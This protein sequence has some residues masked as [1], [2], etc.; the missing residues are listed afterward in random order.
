MP[1]N[2]NP[3]TVPDER[4][5]KVLAEILL[6]EEAGEPLDLSRAVRTH[7][8]LEGP[9]REYFRDRDGFDR[10][11]SNPAPTASRPAVPPP[12][13]LASGSQFAG[14]EIVRELGRGGMGVV[15]LAQQRS[16]KRPVALKLIRMDRL[17]HLSARQ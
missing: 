4:F 13:D 17:A 12:P 3:S 16:A 10:L 7:P 14:Y 11:A 15:Y 5:E 1:D 9:L 8:E 6:A 2:P